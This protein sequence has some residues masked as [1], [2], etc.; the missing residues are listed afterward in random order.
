MNNKKIW[1]KSVTIV[2]AL[3]SI[4][5]FVSVFKGI[6]LYDLK[7]GPVW[8]GKLFFQI[9]KKL[10]VRI[11][12]LNI[13]P[14][15]TPSKPS[16][17]GNFS[18][19]Y[20]KA[21]SLIQEVTIKN[22][23]IP[24]SFDG[25]FSFLNPHL[26]LHSNL[27]STSGELLIQPKQM[28]LQLNYIKTPFVNFDSSYLELDGEELK[29]GLKIGGYVSPGGGVLYLNGEINT[30]QVTLFL[31]GKIGVVGY[32]G[33]KIEGLD[34]LSG[35]VKY[36]FPKAQPFVHLKIGKGSVDYNNSL[37]VGEV[38]GATINFQ[39]GENISPISVNLKVEKLHLDYNNSLATGSMGGV[40]LNLKSDSNSSR[41]VGDLNLSQ[42]RL[43]YNHSLAKGVVKGGN[44]R[45]KVGGGDS[46]EVEGKIA[47]VVGEYNRTNRGTL[48]KLFFHLKNN[49][50][51]GVVNHFRATAPTFFVKK[52]AGR[53]LN[54]SF[55]IE[56]QLFS[57]LLWGVGV[58]T[59]QIEGNRVG[60]YLSKLLVAGALKEGKFSG[61]MERVGVR[62]KGKYPVKL[63]F[64]KGGVN[65]NWKKMEYRG[66]LQKA[67]MN[68][69][70]NLVDVKEINLTYTPKKMAVIGKVV[71]V[72]TPQVNGKIGGLAVEKLKKGIAYSL[73][74]GIFKGKQFPFQFQFPT[75]FGN[76]HKVELPYGRFKALGAPG[77]IGK[78]IF[79]IDQ[80]RG[81]IQW[82]KY[83][84]L[85]VSPIEINLTDKM[86]VI[87]FESNTTL[88]PRL[89]TL[90]KKGAHI[91]LPVV[92]K[93]G[94]N[95][96]VGWIKI[97]FSNPSPIYNINAQISDALFQITTLPLAL[98]K[99]IAQVNPD[100]I[101]FQV[102]NLLLTLPGGGEF[103]F[104]GSGQLPM[105]VKR[106][107]LDGNLT[108]HYLP[109]LKM[110]NFPE[111]ATLDLNNLQLT[112]ANLGGKVDIKK[113]WVELP[114]QPV[115]KYTP[116]T[117]LI[118]NGEVNLSYAS[119]LK[120]N[121]DVLLTTPIFPAQPNPH[122]LR[123]QVEIGK[124]INLT[125]PPYGKVEIAGENIHFSLHDMEINLTQ[126]PDLAQKV[127]ENMK[128][129]EKKGKGGEVNTT[130]ET[131]VTTPSPT[132]T[133]Q[134]REQKGKKGES[135]LTIVG[136]LKNLTLHYN[137]FTIPIQKGNV[138][139][140]RG[141][142]KKLK[143][144]VEPPL[145]VE[146]YQHNG[147]TIARWNKLD[148][149]LFE[150][151]TGYKEI[152]GQLNLYG[153]AVVTPYGYTLV[154]VRLKDTIITK[155]KLLNNLLA[156]LNTL[157]AILSFRS[158]GFSGKG[159]KIEK[160]GITAIIIGDT[161]H[162]TRG[163]VLDKNQNL[164]LFFWGYIYPKTKKMDMMIRVIVPIKVKYIPVVGPLLSYIVFGKSGGLVV[165]VKATGDLADPS[166][167]VSTVK[168]VA[169]AP[170]K[171]FMRVLKAP[172]KLRSIYRPDDY[173]GGA[174]EGEE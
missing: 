6:S 116:F 49:Q 95:W 87:S 136:E 55:D 115:V 92:E 39:T 133:A 150:K 31:E 141:E 71:E 93:K 65:G 25:N 42:L 135:N 63:L 124:E 126:L 105:K 33:V 109:F 114:L 57:L 144:L 14:S 21:L 88:N 7:F 119:P 97:P 160:G 10:V 59:T 127:V 158:L 145:K 27:V 107:I 28:G 148:K 129:W 82:V 85:E 157:P 60:G 8:I 164:N 12:D 51:F 58:Q 30:T 120:I 99:A 37:A 2:T 34:Q 38:D 16:E 147:Y 137:Q 1:I 172:F 113:S 69:Q 161:I 171:I 84:G 166:L 98:K 91:N 94:R 104:T 20:L 26:E 96:I 165:D 64:S 77:E 53:D 40:I 24:G 73:A 52:L 75:L 35:N 101:Q 132:A 78:V 22:I 111:K 41:L 151:L 154:N 146:A 168:D 23:H 11:Y 80:K 131:N 81:K 90:L 173:Y 128:R 163:A 159:Y 70:K 169:S 61:E 48:S 17:L 47:K 29:K 162:I 106:L 83:S 79:N 118:E 45:F 134:K 112:L 117:P 142:L 3:M 56:N 89:L 167:S 46:P 36:I 13:T 149:A 54:L 67:V 170:F 138:D 130:A 19:K 9:D 72:E 102:S 139:Y 121:G 125:L 156:L 108:L 44:I 5:G 43:D 66:T 32:Q 4:V 100:Q 152:F 74:S 174:M 153:G 18:L 155:M 140:R 143:I 62:V 123:T 122:L 68:Y 15:N 110:D 76:L 86:A 103:G 50:L